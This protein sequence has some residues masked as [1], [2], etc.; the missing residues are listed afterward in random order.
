LAFC[1][2]QAEVLETGKFYF[3]DGTTY[4]GQY[5]VLGLPPPVAAEPAKKGAKKKDEEP[6]AAPA[7]PPKPVRHGKGAWGDRHTG[8]QEQAVTVPLPCWPLHSCSG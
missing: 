1:A 4:E 7:E 6:A 2:Q 8:V 5:K 3:E